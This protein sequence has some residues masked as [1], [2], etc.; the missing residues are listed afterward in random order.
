MGVDPV[1]I[2]NRVIIFLFMKNIYNKDRRRV[3]GTKTINTLAG[4]FKLAHC[5]LLKLKRYEGL[6]YNGEQEIGKINQIVDLSKD[7]S[8]TGKIKQSNRSTLNKTNK[9]YLLGTCWK[10]GK[11]GHL[12][13]ENTNTH[14]TMN[15]SSNMQSHSLAINP[16]K[17]A[18]SS[19]QAPQTTNQI[20]YPT[21][22][23]LIRVPT[24]TQQITADF[25]LSQEAWDHLSIEM[26]E[27]VETNTHLESC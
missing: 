17:N 6:V 11:F 4:A 14:N 20:R 21:T 19:L 3:A 22:I 24:L 18:Q 1:N 25:Q 13:K 10:C 7:V 16:I 5:N 27:M 2:T 12:A 9:I 23:V 8:G 26:N 15:Q